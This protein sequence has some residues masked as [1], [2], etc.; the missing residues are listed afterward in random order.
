MILVSPSTAAAL[1][2]LGSFA[3]FGSGVTIGNSSKIGH[4][5]LYSPDK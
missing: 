4:Y 5:N 2:L 3:V 1:N